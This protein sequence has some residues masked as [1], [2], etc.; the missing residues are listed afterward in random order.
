MADRLKRSD[1]AAGNVVLKLKTADFRIL[2]RSRRLESPT[3]LADRL[4]RAAATLLLAEADGRHFRLIGVGTGDLAA[5][6]Q[7]DPPDLL[8]PAAER[9]AQIERLVDQVKAEVGE[10]AIARGRGWSPRR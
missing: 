7:A 1:L 4:Y 9:S 3:Q 8:D 5:A 2:T 6:A 10:A